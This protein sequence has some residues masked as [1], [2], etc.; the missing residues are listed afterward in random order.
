[1]GRLA[2]PITSAIILRAIPHHFEILR[3][4]GFSLQA[5]RNLNTMAF[6]RFDDLGSAF[7]F[8]PEHGATAING[9]AIAVD[10]D[11]IDIGCALGFA[12]FED[13]VAFIDHGVERAFDD[14]LIADFA[15]RQV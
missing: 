11:Y 14:L 6:K 4:S 15:L 10:P 5:L 3:L 13:F 12:F 1:M 2:A 7:Q 8:A 9:P